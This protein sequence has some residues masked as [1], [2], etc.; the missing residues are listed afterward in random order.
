VL[1]G[2]LAPLPKKGAQPL[3]NFGPCLLWPNG[4]MDQNATWYGGI[5]LVQGHN[6]LDRDPVVNL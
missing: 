6:V 5:G 1:D 3:A 2:D 4:R